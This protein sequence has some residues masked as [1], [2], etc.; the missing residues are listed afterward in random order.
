MLDGCLGRIRI[1]DSLAAVEKLVGRKVELQFAGDERA[2]L[3][4]ESDQDIRRLGIALPSG[5]PIKAADIFFV[6]RSPQPV[7]D[8]IS[9]GISCEDVQRL[10][11]QV[12]ARGISTL[13]ATKGGWRVDHKKRP[14][15]F[16]WGADTAPVCR[17]WMRR[18]DLR[19]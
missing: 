7:V 18:S 17:L 16:M 14:R 10:R 13:A 3:S 1:G 12:E 6:T 9:L 2:G 4:L 15:E 19:R 8:M 5:S 11:T